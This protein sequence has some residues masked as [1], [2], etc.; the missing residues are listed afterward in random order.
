MESS[1]LEIVENE[2]FIDFSELGDLLIEMIFSHESTEDL[3]HT[4][5]DKNLTGKL[6]LLERVLETC[7]TLKNK[8]LDSS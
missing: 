2:N 1:A 4:E 5:V 8:Y 7:P 3:I 6:N